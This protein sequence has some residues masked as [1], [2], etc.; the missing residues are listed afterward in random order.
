MSNHTDPTLSCPE[1][2]TDVLG[3]FTIASII[4]LFI[5]YTQFRPWKDKTGD[6]SSSVTKPA[7]IALVIAFIL[8]LVMIWGVWAEAVPGSALYMAF[9]CIF[10]STQL[11]FI[12]SATDVSLATNTQ[13]VLLFGASAKIA[14]LVY[15]FDNM[16]GIKYAG[17]L[18]TLYASLYEAGWWAF[19]VYPTGSTG[20]LGRCFPKKTVTSHKMTGNI[21]QDQ[22]WS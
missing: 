9:A 10:Y 2:A 13:V 20:L 16:S 17:L 21:A 8:D 1:D 7:L 19:R 12:P 22:A 6:L 18:S 15:V 5:T 3:G 11:A 14:G 4:V